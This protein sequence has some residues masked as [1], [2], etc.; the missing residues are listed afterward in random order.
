[1]Q[2]ALGGKLNAEGGSS[3]ER[4][5]WRCACEVWQGLTD[6]ALHTLGKAV[7]LQPE[8][9]P[10]TYLKLNFVY[11]AFTFSELP[12]AAAVYLKAM[13]VLE[14]SRQP[15]GSWGTATSH[16]FTSL[17]CC[18]AAEFTAPSPEE[19]QRIAQRLI[20]TAPNEPM[21]WALCGTAHAS[22]SSVHNSAEALK[23][24]N[25]A[26]ALCTD[27]PAALIEHHGYLQIAELID[28]EGRLH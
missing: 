4:L 7:R 14:L 24:F 12:W 21:A 17:Y 9:L 26:A 6:R 2:A 27:D 25:R 20:E 3:F 22:S 16:T 5:F 13:E 23:C 8:R 11:D 18:P 10:E 1:M 28:R 15:A 19:R